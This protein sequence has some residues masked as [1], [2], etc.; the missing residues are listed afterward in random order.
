MAMFNRRVAPTFDISAVAQFRDS[1][2]SGKVR[3]SMDSPRHISQKG[4]SFAEMRIKLGDIKIFELH[5][6]VKICIG[7]GKVCRR[8]LS[9]V[10]VKLKFLYFLK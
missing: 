9:F 1:V 10:L 7:G 2:T 3:T 8:Y 4:E 6:F 5:F